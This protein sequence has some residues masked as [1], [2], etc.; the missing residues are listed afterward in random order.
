MSFDEV[1]TGAF[2][3]WRIITKFAAKIVE[4]TTD[5]LQSRQLLHVFD[6]IQCVDIECRLQQFDDLNI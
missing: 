6:V 5:M 4:K 2:I 1:T 3:S